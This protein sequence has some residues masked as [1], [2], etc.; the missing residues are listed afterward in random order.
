MI[1]YLTTVYLSKYNRQPD[2]DKYNIISIIYPSHWFVALW[3]IIVFSSHDVYHGIG[4]PVK[5]ALSDER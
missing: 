5:A 1:R 4:W 2:R 3:W